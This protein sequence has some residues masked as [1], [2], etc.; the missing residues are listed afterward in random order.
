MRRRYTGT[1]DT[2]TITK[3]TYTVKDNKM[4]KQNTEKQTNGMK[5]NMVALTV[6]SKRRIKYP[7]KNKSVSQSGV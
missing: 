6:A 2:I 7:N 5:R 4:L 1:L 3:H